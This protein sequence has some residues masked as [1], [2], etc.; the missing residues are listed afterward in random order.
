M[1]GEEEAEEQKEEKEEDKK[2][3]KNNCV[4]SSAMF[5]HSASFRTFLLEH[6]KLSNLR[7]W[8]TI[9]TALSL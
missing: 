2:K 3:N 6:E 9:S 7:S 8:K 5:N 4:F 1:K